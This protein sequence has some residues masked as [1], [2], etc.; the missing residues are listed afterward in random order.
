MVDE[1]ALKS[2]EFDKV[3]QKVSDYCV[4][5]NSKEKAKRMMPEDNFLQAKHLQD[6][7]AEGFALLYDGGVSGIEFYDNLEDI[8]ERSEKG[9]TLSMGELLR[10][11]RFLKSCRILQSTVS[12][13][14]VDA[15]I[16]KTQVS[17]IYTDSYLEMK[18]SQKFF[19]KI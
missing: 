2:L 14:N 19:P 15:P 7:T 8:P 4:L 10:V 9:S 3:A 13:C 12:S 6:K 5:Y 1:R 17:A 16:L 18:F 11:A